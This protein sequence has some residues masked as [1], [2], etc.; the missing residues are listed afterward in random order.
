MGAYAE[1]IL[2]QNSFKIIKFLI[3]RVLSDF[4]YHLKLSG[5]AE[6]CTT[7]VGFC[8]TREHYDPGKACQGQTL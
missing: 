5:A 2:F 7:R 8:L 3:D 6:R 1:C 4:Q